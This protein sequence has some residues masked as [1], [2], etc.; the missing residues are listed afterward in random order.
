MRRDAVIYRTSADGRICVALD[1]AFAPELLDYISQDTRH[2]KKFDYIVEL[3]INKL[4]N[5]DLYDKEDINERCK[6]V[7][8]MKFFKGQ[9]NDRIY[10]KQGSLSDETGKPVFVVIAARLHL[11]KKSETNS[12]AE[13]N[14]IETVASYQYDYTTFSNLDD[15]DDPA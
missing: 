4:R 9:E 3:L 6:D 15:D 12:K 1:L 8:A 14:L 11:K 2:Q 13:I 7:T 5:T 10:C